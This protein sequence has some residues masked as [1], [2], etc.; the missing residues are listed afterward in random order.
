MTLSH[1][2]MRRLASLVCGSLV[3]LSLLSL[4]SCIGQTAGNETDKAIK[5]PILPFAT[6]TSAKGFSPWGITVGPDG[7]LWFTLTGDT[8][9]GQMRVSDGVITAYPVTTQ[10]SGLLGI[11][12]GPDNNLW[13]TE[14]GLIEAGGNK[15]GCVSTVGVPCGEVDIPGP[16]GRVW[17]IT[18]GPDDNL[19][20]ME[21]VGN[22]IRRFDVTQKK[23]TLSG[24]RAPTAA[25]RASSPVPM[26]TSG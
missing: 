17:G 22:K 16:W 20:T 4:A 21:L 5:T 3:A 2:C 25:W 13:F 8:K 14:S 7:H 15:I 9:V 26:A 12:A 10:I 11:T 19:W 18:R 1:R 6:D 23:F 24:T